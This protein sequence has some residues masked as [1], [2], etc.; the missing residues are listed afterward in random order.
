[1]PVT[2]VGET[3]GTRNLRPRLPSPEDTIYIIIIII[4]INIEGK[5]S[6]RIIKFII[7]A[8]WIKESNTNK[9]II[10]V[11]IGE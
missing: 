5:I 2:D 8:K 4:I 3:S 11:C 1:M 7:H 10:W 9:I 6:R